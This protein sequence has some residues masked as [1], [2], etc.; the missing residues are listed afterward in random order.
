M[1][2]EFINGQLTDSEIQTLF[3]EFDYTTDIETN[4]DTITFAVE[5]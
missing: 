1:S 5:K 2:C 3:T 4:I